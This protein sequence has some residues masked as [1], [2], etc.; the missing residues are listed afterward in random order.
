[1]FGKCLYCGHGQPCPSNINVVLVNKFTDLYA[2]GDDYAHG[3]YQALE[4]KAYE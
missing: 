1:M 3:H 4:P 2:V